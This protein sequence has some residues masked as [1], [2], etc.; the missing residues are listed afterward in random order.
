VD[1]LRAR[2]PRRIVG[3]RIMLMVVTVA[4]CGGL[5]LAFCLPRAGAKTYSA[6]DDPQKPA[7]AFL[8]SDDRNVEEF[9]KEFGLSDEKVQEVLAVVHEEDGALDKEYDE[10]DQI[11]EANE[12]ASETKIENKIAASDFDEKVKKVVAKTKSDVEKLLPKGKADD[13]GPWVDEQWQAE[14][15]AYEAASEDSYRASSTGYS[16]RVW[17]SYYR[18]NTRYEVALPHKKVK[19]SGGRKVRITDV[20]KGTSARAPVKETGPWN[21]R[22]NYWRAPRDRSMWKD[23]PRCVPEAQAAFFRD[24][25]RGKD[26]FGREVKNPAGIDITPA[27]ARRMDVWRKIQRRGLIKVRVQYLWGNG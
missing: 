23:L 20:R 3:L 11:V 2:W 22:D 25:N 19:F 21:I 4:V 15:A 7:L 16:C 18:G 6:Y 12:G 9:Q 26:Q 17:L 13:L 10:S 5:A 1:S 14:S 27:V 8:L 24:Y